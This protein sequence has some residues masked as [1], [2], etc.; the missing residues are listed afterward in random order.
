M[1]YA[2]PNGSKKSLLLHFQEIDMP[3]PGSCH[4]FDCQPSMLRFISQ[5]T[6]QLRNCAFAISQA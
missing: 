3:E 2:E 1:S 5:K 4:H 6:A